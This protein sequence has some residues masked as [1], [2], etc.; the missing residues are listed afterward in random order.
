MVQQLTN[1]VNGLMA[2]Q[3]NPRCFK[4]INIHSLGMVYQN[5]RTAGIKTQL[6][7]GFLVE[8]DWTMQGRKVELLLDKFPA[9]KCGVWEIGGKMGVKNT[10]IVFL[11]ADTT[12][13]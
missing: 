10:Q 2:K 1:F 11:P 12:T 4:H 5:N 7:I 8:F 9:H 13:K 3:K 6:M